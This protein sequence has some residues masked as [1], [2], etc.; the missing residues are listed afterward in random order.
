MAGRI[1]ERSSQKRI[2]R[3]KHMEEKHWRGDPSFL[4]LKSKY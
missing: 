4:M 1:V 2:R 3:E